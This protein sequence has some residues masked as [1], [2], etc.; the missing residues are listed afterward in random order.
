MTLMMANGPPLST[1]R[2]MPTVSILVVSPSW[3]CTFSAL[4]PIRLG[5]LTHRILLPRHKAP[6]DNVRRSALQPRSHLGGRILVGLGLVAI[7]MVKEMFRDLPRKKN[8]FFMS[9]N[10]MAVAEDIRDRIGIIHR[11]QPLA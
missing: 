2:A 6:P 8:T 1:F 4:R 10:T 7:S 3:P 5:R 9:T 11:G